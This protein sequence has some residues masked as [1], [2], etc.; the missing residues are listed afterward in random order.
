MHYLY[1]PSP[2]EELLVRGRYEVVDAL[3]AHW[4]TEA[5]ECYRNGGSPV[6]SWRSEWQEEAGTRLLTHTV[7]SPEAVERLKMR[8]L[9]PGL[10]SHTITVTPMDDA[11]MVNN[12]GE[13]SEIELPEGYGLFAPLPSLARL[14][15]PFDLASE[16]REIGMVLLLRLYRTERLYLRPVKF[17]YTALGLREFTVR[18]ATLLGKGWRMEV[19]GLLSQEGWFDR[20]GTCLLWRVE[21]GSS[22]WEARLVEWIR[23][24]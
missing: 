2:A 18:S 16:Q 1:R 19:P 14:A 23:F 7:I 20:N 13:I 9:T 4:A 24:G 5:W 22:A 17:G 6:Q 12:E 8:L 15:F 11:V 3:G 21:E 10:P